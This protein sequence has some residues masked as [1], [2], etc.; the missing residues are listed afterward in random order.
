MSH[1]GHRLSAL[2]DG[3]LG[4]VERDRVLVHL[5]GCEPCCREASA[6]RMLK[7]RMNSLGGAPADSDLTHRL[8]GL[9]AAATAFGDQYMHP[10][11]SGWLWPEPLPG[12]GA[13]ARELRPGRAMVAGCF[14]FLVVGL[15][16]AAF[17]AGGGDGQAG[18]QI[19]PQVGVFMAQ[20]EI[21]TGEVPGTRSAMPTP[22][23]RSAL[24]RVP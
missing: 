15:G 24:P 5:A 9:A 23:V 14:A 3:E 22:T 7:R 11:T 12:G 8:M 1:L 19:T 18:P 17:A 21:T 4:D 2:I 10:D 16:A 6:L 13:A 20:H